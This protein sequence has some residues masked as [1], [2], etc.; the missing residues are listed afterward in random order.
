MH[1]PEVPGAAAGR[2]RPGLRGGVPAAAQ[3][4]AADGAAHARPAG[5]TKGIWEGLEKKKE[6][7][8]ISLT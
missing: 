4:A 3:R 5:S 7:T 8:F 6:Q 1:H 2:P